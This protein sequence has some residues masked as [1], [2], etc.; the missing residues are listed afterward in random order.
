[1][2]FE[3]T[4]YLEA[5]KNGER[6]YRVLTEAL[7]KTKWIAVGTFTWRGKATPVAIRTRQEIVLSKR[8]DLAP[9]HPQG[10]GEASDTLKAGR[11]LRGGLSEGSRAP[12]A[13][14][15]R[16]EKIVD[17]Q[18]RP[19]HAAHRPELRGG[20]LRDVGGRRRSQASHRA[21]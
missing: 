13:S 7:E 21:G 15:V 19:P 4:Y 8:N 5:D 6:G 2:Y 10:D 17:A 9:R 12:R 20:C 18:R 11:A 1:V 14:D 16:R 3:D